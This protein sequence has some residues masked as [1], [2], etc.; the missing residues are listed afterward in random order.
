MSPGEDGR[1]SLSCR[2]VNSISDYG[3]LCALDV[4]GLAHNVGADEDVFNE[5]KEQLTRSEDGSYETSLPWKPGQ[6]P[7][8]S[9]REGSLRRLNSLLRKLK[10]TDMLPQY[11]AVI[12]EQIDE[13]IVE[14]APAVITGKE[15]YLPIAL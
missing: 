15:F 7:L 6:Q 1:E 5:F 8:L 4:L 14:K 9:N 3:N 10:Q 2:A 11:D 12:R 13:G